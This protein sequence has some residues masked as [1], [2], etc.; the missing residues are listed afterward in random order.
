MLSVIGG[1]YMPGYRSSIVNPEVKSAII[2]S[3]SVAH[4]A[5][6]EGIEAVSKSTRNHCPGRSLCALHFTQIPL[7]AAI[8]L[9]LI[10]E[11]TTSAATA[12][13]SVTVPNTF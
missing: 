12:H 7:P 5:N 4:N 2:N 9:V 10:S 6:L 11:Q 1:W 13:I 8:T 3:C